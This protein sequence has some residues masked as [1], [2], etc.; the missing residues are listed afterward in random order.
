MIIVLQCAVLFRNQE[1]INCCDY[2]VRIT[3]DDD[4]RGSHSVS[5]T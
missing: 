1:H 3:I 2:K 5:V 4:E